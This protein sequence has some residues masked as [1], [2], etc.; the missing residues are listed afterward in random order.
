MLQLVRSIL[1][2][3]KTLEV[4]PIVVDEKNMILGG[5]M[6][7][8]A[9]NIIAQMS[10]EELTDEIQRI[11]YK[12]ENEKELLYRIWLQW[13]QNPTCYIERANLEKEDRKQFII[14]DNINYGE[15]DE[16]L[17]KGF[18]KELLCDLSLSKWEEVEEDNQTESKV[19][20]NTKLLNNPIFE[21]ERKRL[22]II[23]S[24]DDKEKMKAV[25]GLIPDRQMY[26]I[27][28]L[29]NVKK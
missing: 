24:E 9:L 22:I 10:E 11:P 23:Y 6:R 15:W 19:E 3:P 8:K 16:D 29:L 1:A 26:L 27:E 7:F 4:R 5:N 21:A 25:F 17:L 14:K 13:Q 2:L 12:H 28:E 18:D 20:S